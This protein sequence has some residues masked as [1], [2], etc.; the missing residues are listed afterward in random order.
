MVE[1]IERGQVGQMSG[2]HLEFVPFEQLATFG[3]AHLGWGQPCKGPEAMMQS[4]EVVAVA[5]KVAACI[6][7]YP[8]TAVGGTFAA[9]HY[10]EAVAAAY[11]SRAIPYQPNDRWYEELQYLNDQE[12][13]EWCCDLDRH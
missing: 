4:F 11:A 10:F 9:R 13:H 2:F 1:G 6:V 3:R 7:P 8:V 5:G 12:R